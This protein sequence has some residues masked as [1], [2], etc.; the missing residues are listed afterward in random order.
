MAK[1]FLIGLM[2]ILI[3]AIFWLVPNLD[4]LTMAIELPEDLQD[5]LNQAATDFNF[6]YSAPT[7][8]ESVDQATE[9]LDQTLNR[10]ASL[11]APMLEA[12]SPVPEGQKVAPSPRHPD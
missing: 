11:K 2:S 5:L 6:P 9:R 3:A 1:S 4:R 12:P 7:E 10:R 8:E